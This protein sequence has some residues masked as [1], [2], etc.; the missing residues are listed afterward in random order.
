MNGAAEDPAALRMEQ[1]DVDEVW[2]GDC[3][4]D[5]SIS[6]AV[7]SDYRRL[8]CSLAALACGGVCWRW[9]WTR[10]WPSERRRQVYGVA[11]QRE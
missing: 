9:F 8:A 1:D 4:E 2:A 11:T 6:M 7:D 5:R 3:L 10:K